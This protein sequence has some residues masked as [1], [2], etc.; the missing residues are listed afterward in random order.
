[1]ERGGGK[2]KKGARL[3]LGELGQIV[4]VLWG[5]REGRGGVRANPKWR[6]G[7]S[8]EKDYL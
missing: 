1:M 7:Y 5:A 6:K 3:R 2:M 8:R 4:S